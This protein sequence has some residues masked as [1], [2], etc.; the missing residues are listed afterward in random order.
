[1]AYALNPDSQKLQDLIAQ[2]R[3]SPHW[4]RVYCKDGAIFEGD[5]DCWT[6]TAIGGD[7]DV[8][9]LRFVLRDGRGYTVA[10]VDID[11]FEVL[12]PR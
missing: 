4:A 2:T 7:E 3:F 9:A 12:E 6:Y 8:D 5:A 10:G 1:M 11:R